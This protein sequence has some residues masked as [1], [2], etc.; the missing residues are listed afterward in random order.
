MDIV[1]NGFGFWNTIPT[2]RR[3]RTGSRE[4]MSSPSRRIRP[5][6]RVWGTVSWSRLMHR[7]SVDLPQPEGPMMALTWRSG[8]SIEISETARF[9]P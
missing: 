9:V 4:R 2:R 1:T 3:T 5:S 8:K 6:T 7:M